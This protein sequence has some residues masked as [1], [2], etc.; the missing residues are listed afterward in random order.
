ML[1]LDGAPGSN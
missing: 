1:D